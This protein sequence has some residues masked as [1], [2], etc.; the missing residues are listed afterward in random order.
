MEL[1]CLKRRSIVDSPHR[2]KFQIVD[3]NSNRRWSSE[4][5]VS[6]TVCKH[7]KELSWILDMLWSNTWVQKLMHQSLHTKLYISPFHKKIVSW[8]I[9]LKIHSATFFCGNSLPNATLEWL[10]FKKIFSEPNRIFYWITTIEISKVVFVR[11]FPQKN[12]AE[13]IFRHILQD[14]I[15]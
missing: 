14:T 10:F 7:R 8:R 11:G 9:C 13:C 1:A 2:P 3:S 15:F 4:T 6:L 12:V 5:S